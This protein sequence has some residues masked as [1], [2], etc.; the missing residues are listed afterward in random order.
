MPDLRTLRQRRGLTIFEVAQRSGLTARAIAELEF[1]MRPFDIAERLAL[2]H[3]YDLAPEDLKAPQTMLASRS[4]QYLANILSRQLILATLVSTVM[5]MVLFGKAVYGAESHTPTPSVRPLAR[6]A[7]LGVHLSRPDLFAPITSSRRRPDITLPHDVLEPASVATAPI[8]T[9]TAT[10]R[11]FPSAIRRAA[12]SATPQP[13][14]TEEST[15]LPAEA[16]GPMSAAILELAPTEMPSLLPTEVPIVVPTEVPN[17]APTDT[18]SPAPTELLS[19]M[20]AQAPSP[21]PPEVPSPTPEAPTLTPEALSPT[22]PQAPSP[23]APEAPSPSGAAMAQD[24]SVFMPLAADGSFH[25][26]IVAALE[27]NNGALQRVVIPPD[28]IWSFNRSIGDPDLLPLDSVYG[29]HG[30]GWCDLA[31]RYVMVLRPFLPRESF[32]FIRHI[33]S[34]GLGLEGV[35]DDDAVVIW[36]SNGASDEQDLR[37]HNTSGR[38]ITIQVTLVGDGV[39]FQATLA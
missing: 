33:D 39:Q 23:T 16:P 11:L 12:Q 28:A 7:S 35:P 2:A 34:T 30:G 20:P 37:I 14:P 13:A 25:Q 26:N 4:W 19:S 15:A 31:S 22:P 6:E 29:V 3:V 1:G 17:P 27:A 38:T 36:N 21:T 32:V 10:P 8:A 24:N 5:A 9:P 18:L